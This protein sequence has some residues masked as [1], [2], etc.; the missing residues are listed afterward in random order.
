MMKTRPRNKHTQA[1]G[2]HSL[3][4][5][6]EQS[7]ARNHP[8]C[9]IPPRA[10]PLTSQMGNIAITALLFIL[11]LTFVNAQ[12]TQDPG[13][14][15]Q[16]A[17]KT[18]NEITGTV[19]VCYRW[20]AGFEGNKS[21]YRSVVNLGQG[22]KLLNFNINM[23]DTQGTNPYV[24]RLSISAS[25]WGGDPYNTARVFA[26][27]YDAYQVSFDYRNVLYFNFIPSYANPLLSSGVLLGEHSSDITRRTID[28]NVTLFPQSRIIPSFGFSRATGTG[29]GITTFTADNNEYAIQD[30]VNNSSN[31]VKG[32]VTF[33][34]PK[35]SF[36][37]EQGVVFFDDKQNIFQ[38]AGTNLGNRRVPVLG[39]TLS[40]NSL[41]ESLHSHG[42]TPVS[43]LQFTASPFDNLTVSGRFV[44]SKSN[45]DFNYQ[46]Q[47]AGNFLAFD[48]SRMFTGD[49]ADGLASDNRPHMLGNFSI[50]YHPVKRLSIL[51]SYMTDHFRTSSAASLLRTVTGTSPI[52]LPPDPNNSAGF[53]SIDG[54]RLDVDITQN[55]IEAVFAITPRISIRAGHR[56]QTSDTRIQTFSEDPS[57]ESIS[58]H[59]NSALAGLRIRPSR[60]AEFSFDLEKGL[61]NQVFARIDS[62]DS[63][64]VRMRGRYTPLEGLILTGSFTLLDHENKNPGVGYNFQS[65]NYSGS[66]TY[67]PGGGGRLAASLDYSRT[68]LKTDINYIVPQT[69]TIARS[70][71]SEDSQY[72]GANVDLGIFK[73]A[74][75]NL[76]YGILTSS[77]SRPLNYHQPRIYLEVPIHKR[78]MWTSE[79]RYYDYVEKGFRIENFKNNLITTGFRITY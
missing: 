21:M 35:A 27:K 24:D 69:F 78:V 54:T 9:T 6:A 67:A 36:M 71:Y 17:A 51:E 64:K 42:T 75:L 52:G 72:A 11:Q 15:T 45:V 4:A 20:I 57:P 16:P 58:M 5:M 40:L 14:T 33:N 41:E 62:L 66:V 48:I 53:T 63:N 13:A 7:F 18:G 76:A 29:P 28:L 49:L 34:F 19:D 44:Y 68:N 25:S 38:T 61:S 8:A 59:R 43:K 37:L 23:N 56:Y 47:A 74:R 73:G 2:F 77:G 31:Y 50:E 65:R 79:W 26:E 46:R 12:T 22:P 32:A 70:L 1:P 3:S 55:Q 10:L 60:K 39:Q 30:T